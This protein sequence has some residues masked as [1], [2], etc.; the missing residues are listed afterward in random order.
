VKQKTWECVHVHEFLCGGWHWQVNIRSP[1]RH[2]NKHTHT[3]T[4]THTPRYS[5]HWCAAKAWQQLI[6]RVVCETTRA[7]R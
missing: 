4:H 3:H 2:V 7:P 6:G 5:T 1:S